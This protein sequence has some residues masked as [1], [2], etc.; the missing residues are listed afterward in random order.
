MYDFHKLRNDSEENEWKHK[1][2]KRGSPYSYLTLIIKKLNGLINYN[3]KLDT[4]YSKL[5]E[6]LLKRQIKS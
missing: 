2:F 5:R 1:Q 4:Y 6:K 3:I